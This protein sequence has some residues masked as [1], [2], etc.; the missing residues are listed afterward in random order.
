[1]SR[2]RERI[3]Y[4]QKEG[5]D[6]KEALD[7]LLENSALNP[8]EI[9]EICLSE[10]KHFDKSILR[11]ALMGNLLKRVP[12]VG[13]YNTHGITILPEDDKQ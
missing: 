10:F 13:R 5:L 11:S 2:L 1:M 9:Y 6:E 4:I 12:L 7:V 3:E 8:N